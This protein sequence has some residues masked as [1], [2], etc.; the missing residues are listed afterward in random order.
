MK[1]R[2]IGGA[3]FAVALM[4]MV[5]IAPPSNAA[6]AK[7]C[8]GTYPCRLLIHMG[9]D[10]F[11]GPI[12]VRC[13]SAATGQI[14]DIWVNEGSNT[15]NGPYAQCPNPWS[16]VIAIRSTGAGYIVRCT[17]ENGP[18]QDYGHSDGSYQFLGTNYYPNSAFWCVSQV[19]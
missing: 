13:K 10:G 4:A 9:D 7:Y 12:G 15:D 3:L 17:V 6:A 14:W 5:L 2:K 16:G 18:W 8:A 11:D 1:Y 19:A